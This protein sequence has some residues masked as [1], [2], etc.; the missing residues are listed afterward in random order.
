MNTICGSCAVSCSASA[1]LQS[2]T[3]A[4]LHCCGR[5]WL[6]CMQVLSADPAESGSAATMASARQP[7]GSE[8]VTAADD[9][10]VRVRAGFQVYQPKRVGRLEP[11]DEASSERGALPGGGARSA[12]ST[13]QQAS[14]T[15]GSAKS[16]VKSASA[17]ETGRLTHLLH[18]FSVAVR[19]LPHISSPVRSYDDINRK[20]SHDRFK[21][22]IF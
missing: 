12:Q 19:K 18:V 3:N 4:G 16:A 15:P 2:T 5:E 10:P 6:L 22:G 20:P 1:M 9:R 13:A 8:N 21:W 11:V 7:R 14:A 17:A